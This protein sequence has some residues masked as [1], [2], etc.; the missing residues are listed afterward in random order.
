MD[1]R[2][3]VR[4][5][6][7]GGGGDAASPMPLSGPIGGGA[8]S[9][10]PM[11]GDR[12]RDRRGLLTRG[13]GEEDAASPLSRTI[14]GGAGPRLPMGGDRDRDRDLVISIVS[15]GGSENLIEGDGVLD[16]VCPL[17]LRCLTSFE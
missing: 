3:F 10:L 7:E 5:P 14:G 8:G 4:L 9:R 2:F 12:D 13:G 11:G 15:C 16:G 17:I 1:F 6:P